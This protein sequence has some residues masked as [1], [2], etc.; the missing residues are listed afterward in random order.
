MFFSARILQGIG[1]VIANVAEIAIIILAISEENRDKAL[2]IIVSGVY[3]GTS[4]SPVVCGFLV[5]HF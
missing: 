4:V 3:L 2:E 5:Q 1:L